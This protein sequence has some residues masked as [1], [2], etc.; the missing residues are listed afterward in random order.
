MPLLHFPPQSQP[1]DREDRGRMAGAHG[2]KS[3][4]ASATSGGTLLI[5]SLGF[6]P[7]A[8]DRP[9]VEQ[10]PVASSVASAHRTAIDQSFLRST[11][12]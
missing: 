2:E 11:S 8:V 3:K 10:S 4:K 1:I 6:D 7:I 12:A 5:T 9:V